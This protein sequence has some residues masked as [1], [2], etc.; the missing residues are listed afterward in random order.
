MTMPKWCS[1]AGAH[2]LLTLSCWSD[3]GT[4]TLAP[5]TLQVHLCNNRQALR[6]ASGGIVPGK[7]AKE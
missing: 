1:E 3:L 7:K 2:R 5:E 6:L 4:R